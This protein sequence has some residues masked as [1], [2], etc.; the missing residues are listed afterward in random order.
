MSDI[1][2]TEEQRLSIIDCACAWS[3]YRKEYGVREADLVAAHKAFRAG[4]KAA[5]EGDQSG[6][7]R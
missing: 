7:V 5:R 6:V 2:M 4:W 1:F 3:D